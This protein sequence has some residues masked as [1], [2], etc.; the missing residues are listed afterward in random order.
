M[1]ISK[2]FEE[3]SLRDQL[4]FAF[5]TEIVRTGLPTSQHART[6]ATTAYELSDAMLQYMKAKES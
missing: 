6:T 1:I 4:A 2:T 3:L 5:A